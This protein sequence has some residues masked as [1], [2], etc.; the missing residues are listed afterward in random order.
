MYF[1]KKTGLR[2]FDWLGRKGKKSI[3]EWDVF[4]K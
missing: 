3:K 2:E 4:Y 1:I